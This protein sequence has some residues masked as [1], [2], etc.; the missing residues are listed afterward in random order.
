M[1]VRLRGNAPRLRDV[2]ISATA[3]D[4]YARGKRLLRQK[5]TDEV[6]NEVHKLR[7]DLHMEL[8]LKPWD[9][10]PLDGPPAP[11]GGSP[12]QLEG[13][14][15]SQTAYLGLERALKERRRAARAGRAQQRANGA[16]SSPPSEP[17]P[18]AA[19]PHSE[20]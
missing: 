6:A 1:P 13:Y 8:G 14:E 11:H 7:I 5:Q 15:R 9:D 10:D 2:E 17:S 19:A 16:P 4:L 12:I 20:E 18:I 3:I